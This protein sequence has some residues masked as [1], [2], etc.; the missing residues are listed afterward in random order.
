MSSNPAL[1]RTVELPQFSIVVHDP[2]ELLF[3]VFPAHQLYLA[4]D[5]YQYYAR[6]AIWLRSMKWLKKST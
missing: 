4:V 1:F 2:D 3:A 5:H 6:H